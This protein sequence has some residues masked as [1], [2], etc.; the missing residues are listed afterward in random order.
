MVFNE[1][2]YDNFLPLH[3]NSYTKANF[4]GN[5]LADRNVLVPSNWDF[6]RTMN[7]RVNRVAP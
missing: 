3:V 2:I 6:T 4:K 5:C 1:K 7:F